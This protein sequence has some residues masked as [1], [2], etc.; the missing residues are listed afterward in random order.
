MAR[1]RRRS[2]RQS[3]S[4]AAT[5]FLVLVLAGVIIW[6]AAAGN[7]GKWIADKVINPLTA[8][9]TPGG[10][11][12]PSAT[13]TANPTQ[14]AAS[15]SDQ[16]T[17]RLTGSVTMGGF[18][19]YCIQWGAFSEQANAQTAAS[20]C[21]SQGA[22]AYIFHDGDL[23]R[24]LGDAFL[25]RDEAVAARD[26]YKAFYKMDACLYELTV[27]G[28]SFKVV[29]TQSQIDAMQQAFD[30]WLTTMKS[31]QSMI[32]SYD[33]MEITAET[34]V[35]RLDEYARDLSATHESLSSA[36][37]NTDDSPVLKSLLSMLEEDSKTLSELSQ[38][39]NNV[40]E[41]VFLRDLKYNFIEMLVSFEQFATG[42][43][44]S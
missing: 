26:V 19:V 10:T 8:T 40:T 37:G 24:V 17:T 1:R 13:T 11:S 30:T 35:L 15:A 28:V 31:V 3:S 20:A 27:P 9:A 18:P 41:V 2:P 32:S 4:R 42:A 39:K 34:C 23:Y 44:S 21:E 43:T 7:I 36:A 14:S 29:A 22:V 16:P 38:E 25:S 33:D 5:I 12:T 6:F